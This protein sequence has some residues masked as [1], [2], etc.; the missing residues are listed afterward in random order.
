MKINTVEAGGGWGKQS[1][2]NVEFKIVTVTGH[3]TA[4]TKL[5]KKWKFPF[6]QNYAKCCM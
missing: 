5:G 4:T 1:C 3:G 6:L 2:G